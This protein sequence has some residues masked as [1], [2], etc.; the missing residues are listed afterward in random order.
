MLTLQGGCVQLK[1][2]AHSPLIFLTFNTLIMDVTIGHVYNVHHSYQ[3][4]N[5]LQME[6]EGSK[7]QKCLEHYQQQHYVFAPMVAFFR[8]MWSRLQIVLNFF[9]EQLIMQRHCSPNTGWF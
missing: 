3:S 9:G 8:S 2:A 7:Q 1:V 5:L 4:G 6:L